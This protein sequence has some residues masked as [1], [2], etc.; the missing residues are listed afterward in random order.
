MT[1]MHVLLLLL[2]YPLLRQSTT[3]LF[4]PICEVVCSPLLLC[5]FLPF[6][7]HISLCLSLPPGPGKC[8]C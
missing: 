7:T 3:S 1:L 2:F 6:L 8:L 4:L 5:L